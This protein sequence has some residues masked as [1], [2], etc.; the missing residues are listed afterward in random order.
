MGFNEIL[1][2]CAA[3]LPAVALCIFVF[4]KDRVEKEPIGLLFGL[5]ALG[6]VIC[7]PASE[8]EGILISFIRSIF[9]PFAYVEN[10]EMYLPT[11]AYHLYLICENFIGIA[12]V[13]EGLK[14][15]V[16]F[17]VTS[18]NKN[19]NSVFDGLIYAVF[20]S[21]G[22]AAFENVLYVLEYGWMNAVMRGILSVPG[23]MFF[24]VI[25]G[26][27]Y[28]F[29]HMVEKAH[30]IEQALKKE[31]FIPKGIVEFSGTRFLALAVLMPVLAHGFYDYCCT[32]NEIWATIALY[33]FVLFLYI[34]CFKKIGKMSK[35]DS[36]DNAVAWA[37]IFKK[38]PEL[39]E[40][41]KQEAKTAGTEGGAK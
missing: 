24:A 6:V 33:A 15:V 34:Y 8:I 19:F 27:Y 22:F 37:L 7:F 39:A 3:L 32:A 5:L 28:S 26:Y 12:L 2:I 14:F 16:L 13:E 17:F 30:G 41:L 40:R 29:S 11:V 1:L 35:H 20:V 31:G 25:M 23:H 18:T 21:L 10:G 4:V 38:Y 36:E 9:E